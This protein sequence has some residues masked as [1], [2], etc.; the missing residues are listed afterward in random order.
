MPYGTKRQSNAGGLEKHSPC[1]HSSL[2][3]DMP[4]TCSNVKHYK[5]FKLRSP[6]VRTT[7]V[8]IPRSK[9][10]SYT[11]V[12]L[13]MKMRKSSDCCTIYSESGRLKVDLGRAYACYS[14]FSTLTGSTCISNWHNRL[15]YIKVTA[16][17]KLT[18]SSRPA[19]PHMRG[20][21]FRSTYFRSLR[22]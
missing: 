7:G 17:F 19:T 6:T 20:N 1:T 11:T 9:G 4:S 10:Q 3:P 5:M 8:A 16:C 12:I 22:S 18:A 14:T 15:L 21:G 2:L 13:G